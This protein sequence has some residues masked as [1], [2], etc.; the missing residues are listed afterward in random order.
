MIHSLFSVPIA[1][2]ENEQSDILNRRLKE[3]FL[4]LEKQGDKYRNIVGTPTVQHNIFESEMNLFSL[5]NSDVKT[6]RKFMLGSIYQF[7]SEI[8]KEDNSNF[9]KLMNHAWFHITR[10][11]GYIGPHNHPMSAWSAVYYVDVGQADPDYPDSGDIRFFNPNTSQTMYRD[12]SNTNLRSPYGN[13][14]LTFKPKNGQLI[15]F[16]SSLYHEVVPYYGNG[17]RICVACNCWVKQ[18]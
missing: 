12:P 4:I 2:I 3:Y 15:I 8:K 7:I 6:L 5:D 16:P 14:L 10:D 1:V 13:G 18:G 17:E 9:N 11:R